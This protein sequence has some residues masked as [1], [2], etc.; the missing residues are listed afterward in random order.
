MTQY[1]WW[2]KGFWVW[3]NADWAMP[4]TKEPRLFRPTEAAALD[5]IREEARANWNNKRRR[6]TAS[7]YNR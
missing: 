2:V 4:Y 7:R 6:E 3:N 5:N 1:F